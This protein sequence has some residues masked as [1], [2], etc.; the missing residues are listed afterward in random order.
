MKYIVFVA[1]A[2]FLNAHLCYA[3]LVD[4]QW[5][6][7]GAHEWAAW[8]KLPGTDG[9]V[10]A[11][12]SNKSTLRESVFALK[13]NKDGVVQWVRPDCQF[14]GEVF[15]QLDVLV[16]SD[17]SI[18]LASAQRGCDYWANPEIK[19]LDSLG[20]TLWQKTLTGS[21]LYAQKIWLYELLNGNIL[22][23]SES[24]Q[25]VINPDGEQQS[26]DHVNFGWQGF[27]S[28][29]NGSYI[30]YNHY[31]IGIPNG[32]QTLDTIDFPGQ[33]MKV[34]QTSGGKWLILGAKKLYLA[35]NDFTTI[36]SLAINTLSPQSALAEAHGFY[37]T[38]GEEGQLYQISSNPFELIATY[39]SHTSFAINHVLEAPNGQLLLSGLTQPGNLFL[40]SEPLSQPVISPSMDIGVVEVSVEKESHGASVSCFSGSATS[41]N[42]GKVQA[43]VKNFGNDTINTFR[44]QSLFSTCS[45]ICPSAGLWYFKDVSDTLAPGQTTWF[46]LAN[47]LSFFLAGSSSGQLEICIQAL[48]PN[49]QLDLENN[50]N[51]S[52]GIGTFTVDVETPETTSPLW[53]L[54]IYPNPAQDKLTLACSAPAPKTVSVFSVLGDKLTEMKS[55]EARVELNI[56]QIPNGIYLVRIYSD[57]Q[58]I[59]KKLVKTDR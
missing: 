40:K 22:V 14:L 36:D 48:L 11:G 57:G 32:F 5:Q 52:C 20:N 17:N 29:S 37:W 19:K 2:L 7:K 4:Y 18:Y 49:G 55:S 42:F 13:V 50:N 27:V 10:A 30:V 21:S 58:S 12:I 33:I 31:K 26:L 34:T 6:F 24:F 23:L 56:E 41:V 9:W 15:A 59:T 45:G 16:H 1:T 38:A 53:D 39:H 8:K 28:S 43:A 3:Q 44:I 25:A 54:S 47:P 46:T 35:N 51:S